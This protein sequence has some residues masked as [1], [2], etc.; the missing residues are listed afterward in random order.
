MLFSNSDSNININNDINVD[1]GFDLYKILVGY[2]LYSLFFLIN[3]IL[4]EVLELCSLFFSVTF[5]IDFYACLT[6]TCRNFIYIFAVLCV[7][8]CLSHQ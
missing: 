3:F 6:C 2:L 4:C 7:H 5:H 8:I 1:H